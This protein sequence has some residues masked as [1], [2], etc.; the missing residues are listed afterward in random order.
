[1]C[2]WFKQG[3]AGFFS[4]R[5]AGEATLKRRPWHRANWPH[6]LFIYFCVVRRLVEWGRFCCLWWS[7]TEH[8]WEFTVWS[9]IRPCN[10]IGQSVGAA[11]WLAMCV[12]LYLISV[13][14]KFRHKNK[15]RYGIPSH[16][17]HCFAMWQIL[18]LLKEQGLI[19]MSR[20]IKSNVSSC[21][22]FTHTTV[23]RNLI[24]I[25]GRWY[26]RH[27]PIV[28][29]CSSVDVGLPYK[30]DFKIGVDVRDSIF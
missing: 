22:L 4:Q 16:F 23:E 19:N 13:G 15:F 28:T 27:V 14:M 10:V 20:I 11:S 5:P 7:Q 8:E 26:I 18:H 17:K 25:T 6:R 29:T 30:Y 24:W 9:A 3:V 21:L 1:V 2:T 12:C